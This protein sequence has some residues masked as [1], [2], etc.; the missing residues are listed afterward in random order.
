MFII[1][2]FNTYFFK[3]SFFLII[4]GIYGVRGDSGS[5]STYGSTRVGVAGDG[6]VGKVMEGRKE[7]VGN[8][9]SMQM[10]NSQAPG[11]SHNVRFM[12]ICF[13]FFL[14]KENGIVIPI[15]ESD[16]SYEE[17][18]ETKKKK[19][20]GKKKKKRM[21]LISVCELEELKTLKETREKGMVVIKG[22]EYCTHDLEN[23]LEAKEKGMVII[24]GEEYNIEELKSF[25]EAK[26]NGLV[27]MRKK[28]GYKKKKKKESD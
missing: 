10:L 8:M 17:S 27:M 3:Y 22:K 2:S 24:E 13:N 23:L 19:K 21:K 12:F 15:V 6:T 28:K 9:D 7:I 14:L 4:G 11:L 16:S 18:S 1:I 5:I 20:K 25:L 26:K